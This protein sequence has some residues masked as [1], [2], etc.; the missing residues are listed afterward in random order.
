[1][2]VHPRVGSKVSFFTIFFALFANSR[3]HAMHTAAAGREG[4][5]LGHRS[6]ANMARACARGVYE[7]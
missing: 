3:V 4:D 2:R 6:D 1:M 5:G 7:R